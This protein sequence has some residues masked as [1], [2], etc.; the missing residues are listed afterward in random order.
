MAYKKGLVARIKRVEAKVAKQKPE[1]KVFTTTINGTAYT[2]GSGAIDFAQLG[3]ITEGTGFNERIGNKIRVHK[4][5]V[6]G[7][8]NSS[9][10]LVLLKSKLAT[11]PTAD[12]FDGIDIPRV[13][14]EFLNNVWTV[15]YQHP[16]K[17]DGVVGGNRMVSFSRSWKAGIP[18]SFDDPATS[19]C[20]HNNLYVAVVN[21]TVGSGTV[22]LNVRYF[23]TDV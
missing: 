22:K 4:V 7:Y 16:P 17:G 6:W 5:E 11:D 2:L 19:S 21:K 14:G 3:E 23:Y 9:F 15:V 10:G 20:T 12:D 1:T 18:V 13:K 8:A